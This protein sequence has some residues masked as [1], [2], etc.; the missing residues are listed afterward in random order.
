ML[1]KYG[2]TFMHRVTSRQIRVKDPGRWN[3]TWTPDKLGFA[4]RSW[5]RFEPAP[6]LED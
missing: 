4:L 2:I 3:I 6:L 5:K 1:R